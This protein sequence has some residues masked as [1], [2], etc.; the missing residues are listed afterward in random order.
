MTKLNNFQK[1]TEIPQAILRYLDEKGTNQAQLARNAGIGEAYVSHIV[2]GKTVIAK[3][4]IKDKYYRALCEAIGYNLTPNWKHFNTTYFAQ[5]IIAIKEARANRTRVCID[6]DTGAGKTHACKEYQKRYPN[7]TYLVTCSAIENSKEFAKNIAE[8]VGVETIGTA[9]TIIKKVIKKLNS[10][11][12]AVLL[13]DEAEHIGNKT[14]YINIIKTL[15]DGLNGKVGFVLLGMGINTIFQK[16]FER[17]KQ[18]FRQTARRFGNREYLNEADFKDDVVKICEELGITNQ[19]AQ[20]FLVNR[21]QNFGDL[22]SI[23]RYALKA[24]E[25]L[26]K[27]VNTTILKSWYE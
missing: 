1:T 7:E 2:K 4:E 23:V 25:K 11:D 10:A 20:T 21:I 18:N 15:A 5:I 22:E 8:A 12:D 16:G 27:E 3:S 6:G 14:G 24:S 17:R 13:I 9:G 19:A 26:G